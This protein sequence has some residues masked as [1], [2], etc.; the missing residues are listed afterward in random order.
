MKSF[1]AHKRGG[2]QTALSAGAVKNSPATEEPEDLKDPQ[3]AHVDALEFEDDVLP[4][5][6]RIG[7]S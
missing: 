2:H 7:G 6:N 1:R 4:I 5:G 3:P